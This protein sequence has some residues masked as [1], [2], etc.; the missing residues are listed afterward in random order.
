MLVENPEEEG[1]Y[2]EDLDINVKIILNYILNE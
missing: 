1:D 2:L